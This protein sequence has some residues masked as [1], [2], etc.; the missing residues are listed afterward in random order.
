MA[1]LFL[2]TETFVSFCKLLSQVVILSLI[3]WELKLEPKT[4]KLLLSFR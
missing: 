2:L 3:L 4:R 1:S